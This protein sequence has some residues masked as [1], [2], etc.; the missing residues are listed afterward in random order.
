MTIELMCLVLVGL[1]CCTGTGG[2]EQPR[3]PFLE[4]YYWLKFQTSPE[5]VIIKGA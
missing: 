2:D 3:Y 5:C 4:G 1:L